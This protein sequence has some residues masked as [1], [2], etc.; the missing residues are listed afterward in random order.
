MKKQ[1]LLTAIAVGLSICGYAQT[2]GTNALGFG[3]TSATEKSS[4]NG[5]TSKNN[6]NSFSLGYGHFIKDNVKLGFEVNYGKSENKSS[7]YNNQAN[8]VYGAGVNYQRYFPLVKTLYAY[9]GGKVAYAHSENSFE[10]QGL[11]KSSYAENEYV[12]G[13][14]GGITWFV[15]KSLALETS[16]LSANVA[17]SKKTNEN[18]ENADNFKHTNTSFNMNTQGFINNLGFKIYFLF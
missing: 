5:G 10:V 11:K 15:F 17:Y 18:N 9:A 6:F 4:S 13:A 7:V 14:Y 16:L 2:K 3:I 12:V 1:I 8:K